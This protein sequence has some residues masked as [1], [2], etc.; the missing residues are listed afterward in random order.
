[1]IDHNNI[2]MDPKRDLAIIE[3][4]SD[5]DLGS[6]HIYP[7]VKELSEIITIGYPKIPLSRY[8]YQVYHKGEITSH[9]ED[10][11]G[12]KLFLFSAKTSPG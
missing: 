12:N 8:A 11:F 9:I 6:F 10:Y 3:L 1:M 2:I 5:F 7:E 4:V